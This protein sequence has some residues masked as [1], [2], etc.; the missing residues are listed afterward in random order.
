MIRQIGFCPFPGRLSRRGSRQ[1]TPSEWTCQRAICH[2]LKPR[3]GT[4]SAITTAPDPPHKDTYDRINL[5]RD[6]THRARYETLSHAGYCVPH[7]PGPQKKP[8]SLPSARAST[9]PHVVS[10]GELQI[11][12]CLCRL[13]LLAPSH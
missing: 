1:T 9:R 2:F 8:G 6:D 13:G 12:P 5:S 4:M 11:A 10:C 7:E 3:V